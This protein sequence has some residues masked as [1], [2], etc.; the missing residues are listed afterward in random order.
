MYLTTKSGRKIELPSDQEDTVITRQAIEDETLHTDEEL[1]Q[2]KPFSELPQPH[3][4]KL[5]AGRPMVEVKKD[6]IT[7]RLSPEVTGF[8]RATGKGW[9]TRID[10]ILQDYVESHKNHRG[11]SK[12]AD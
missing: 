8:F 3:Q 4:K 10:E 5:T 11:E 1:K 6:R 12:G 9:Q 7:I 2:F